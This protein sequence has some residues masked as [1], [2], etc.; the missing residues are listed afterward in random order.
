MQQL[1]FDLYP[2]APPSFDN[3]VV[4]RND[5]ALAAVR[6]F[7]ET[8]PPL[9]PCGIGTGGEGKSL[10]VDPFGH[11]NCQ[12][13]N[14]FEKNLG[15]LLWGAPGSGK[16]HLLH[17]ARALALA[18][19]FSVYTLSRNEILPPLPEWPAPPALW[20]ADDVDS[21]EDG[22][23]SYLFTLYNA[24]KENGGGLLVSA[25][26]PPAR[27]ALREDL[28]TRLGWGG[29]YEIVTLHDEDKLQALIA[30]A[31]TRGLRLPAEIVAYLLKHSRRDMR[32]LVA[33]LDALDR[34]SLSLKRP[35]TLPLVRE[36]LSGGR[37]QGSGIR[38]QESPPL[39]PCGRGVGGE[40]ERGD[41]QVFPPLQGE[42]NPRQ[43]R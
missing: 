20:I 17:A 42:T 8:F 39:S 14:D 12:P 30:H 6:T 24:L 36:W 41:E 19:G 3:F 28:R 32:S 33:V 25:S 38:N 15:L 18:S 43:L 5:E 11:Q 4:G 7:V 13:T 26:A 29:I 40:G 16:T 2:A 23:Q 1:I 31:D 37:D 35:L 10:S 34:Y 27:L 21:A 9:S 22:L